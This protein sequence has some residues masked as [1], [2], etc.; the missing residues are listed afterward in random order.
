MPTSNGCTTTA[1]TAAC[2]GAPGTRPLGCWFDRQLVLGRLG[3]TRPRHGGRL[4][5]DRR[6]VERGPGRLLPGRH[7]GHLHPSRGPTPTRGAGPGIHGRGTAAAAAGDPLSEA[8]TGISDP[9]HNVAPVPDYTQDCLAGGIDN[10]PSCLD[11]VLQAINHAHALEGIRPMVLPAGFAQLSIPDQLFVA[12][13]LERVDRGLPAF[14][15]LTTA[16]NRNAQRGADDGRRSTRPGTVL[17]PRRWRVGRRIVE[18]ARRRLR[19]DVR[20]R[21]RQR[22]PRL[23]APR[24]RRVLGTPQGHPRRLRLR[25]Q[26]RHGRRHRHCTTTPTAATRAVPPWR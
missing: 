6:H 1:R 26:P 17:R 11:A 18:R 25:A 12:V 16:L 19:L 7:A 2:P 9:G 14:G 13:N 20:R 22:Q 5:P 4:R 3:I 15:G 8:D 21:L 24:R 10:S 23:P